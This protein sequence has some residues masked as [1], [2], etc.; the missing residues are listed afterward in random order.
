[1]QSKPSLTVQGTVWTGLL[2]RAQLAPEADS[3]L[4]SPTVILC[5]W[6][7][8]SLLGNPQAPTL[9]ASALISFKEPLRRQDICFYQ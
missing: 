2:S 4:F 1:M 5:W 9:A 3:S 6:K 7:R 8:T